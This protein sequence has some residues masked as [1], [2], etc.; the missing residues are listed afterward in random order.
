MASHKNRGIHIGVGVYL[1]LALG[2]LLL[3]LQ[4]VCAVV[5]AAL[6]HEFCHYA[7]IRLCGARP[8][9][10]RIGSGGM[11][12]AISGLPQWQELVCALAGPL[13]GFLTLAVMRFF[14]RFVFCC[15]AHGIYNL[16]PVYPLDGGRV[17]RCTGSLL[18]G[19]RGERI[20]NALS[21][22]CVFGLVI[23]GGYVAAGWKMG[24]ICLSP[25][26]VLGIRS[27]IIKIPCKA[28]FKRVQ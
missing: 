23:L 7:A 11:E 24:F 18:L 4:W 6:W 2:L 12:M 17:L 21:A 25:G 19:V 1:L 13:G 26:I 27:G 16:L 10:W 22:A 20:A 28:R 15:V 14:P 3:P 9:S 8:M 5:C